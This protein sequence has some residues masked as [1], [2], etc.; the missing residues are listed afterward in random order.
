MKRRGFYNQMQPFVCK[1]SD[2]VLLGELHK[3]FAIN[4]NTHLQS[5]IELF[6]GVFALLGSLGYVYSH[7]KYN[8]LSILDDADSSTYSFTTETLL[9]TIGMENLLLSLIIVLVVHF[10]WSFR[11]DQ[12]L[13]NDIRQMYLSTKNYEFFFE[14]RQYGTNTKIMPGVYEIFFKFGL[15]SQFLL[16]FFTL[17]VLDRA[18]DNGFTISIESLI[19]LICLI[20]ISPFVELSYYYQRCIRNFFDW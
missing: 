16:Y 20:P 19:L 6:V 4:Q 7:W 1:N 15:L 3:Q 17:Y 10:G 11:R 14:K 13:N 5:F 2:L 8:A 12:K 9:A 18:V